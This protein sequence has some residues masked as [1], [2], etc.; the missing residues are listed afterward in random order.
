MNGEL[1]KIP[2]KELRASLVNELNWFKSDDE[3]GQKHES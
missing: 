3:G 2:T 1:K